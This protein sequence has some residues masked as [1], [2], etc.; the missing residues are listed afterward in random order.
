MDRLLKSF[1]LV[2]IIIAVTGF[3]LRP[4]MLKKKAIER[5]TDT[6]KKTLDYWQN[7]DS[8]TGRLLW[9]DPM[10]FPVIYDLTSYKIKKTTIE[11]KGLNSLIKIYVFLDFAPASLYPAGKIWI[12]EVKQENMLCKVV[13]FHITAEN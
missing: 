4:V 12:F 1:I 11:K 5:A 13:N 2:I 3:A 6:V 7:G 8:A 9:E 10:K